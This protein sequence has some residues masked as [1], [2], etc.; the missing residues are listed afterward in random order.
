MKMSD[1]PT[2]TRRFDFLRASITGM[3]CLL[4]LAI[5]CL[6]ATVDGG[7]HSFA[8]MVYAISYFSMLGV[9]IVLLNQESHGFSWMLFLVFEALISFVMISIAVGLIT[10]WLL[11][12]FAI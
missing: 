8:A 3:F 11:M 6:L 2:L 1:Q 5:A 4:H 12:E 10:E 7:Y 9:G